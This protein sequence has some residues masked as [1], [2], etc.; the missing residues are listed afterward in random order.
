M[1]NRNSSRGEMRTPRK[2]KTWAYENFLHP[3]TATNNGGLSLLDQYESSVGIDR[4]QRVTAMRI[5]GEISLVEILAASTRAYVH[6]DL[7]IAWMPDDTAFVNRAPWE[8]GVREAE[9]MQLGHVAGLEGTSPIAGHTV[10]SRP[11][12]AARWQL[13]ITQMRKQPSPGHKLFLAYAS[14]GTQETGTL[15]LR[16]RTAVMLALP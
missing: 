5:V 12:E 13:D 4:T 2:T 10:D 14:D 11:E 7:G 3:I 6:V 9:W 1:V 8:P 16:V 15:G